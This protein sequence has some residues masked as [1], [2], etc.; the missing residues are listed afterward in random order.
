MYEMLVGYPPFYS[1]DPITT[2]KKVT[3]LYAFKQMI[4]VSTKLPLFPLVLA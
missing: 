4:L 3:C 1:D 2:C